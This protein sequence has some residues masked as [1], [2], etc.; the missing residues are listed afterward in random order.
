MD[1]SEYDHKAYEHL[2]NTI[3]YKPIIKTQA[4]ITQSTIDKY[5]TIITTITRSNLSKEDKQQLIKYTRPHA[6]QTRFPSIYFNP[7]TH[8][9]GRPLRPI[10]SGIRWATE[11]AAIL[12]DEILKPHIA[13]NTHLPKDSFQFIQSIEHIQYNLLA[14]DHNLIQLV[15]FDVTAL[16]TSIPQYHAIQRITDTFNQHPHTIPTH[17]ITQ[18]AT[19][20]IT[21]NYF[22]FK[23][24]IYKQA[25]GIAM[26][27][28]AG[29]SIANTYMLEWDKTF[30]KQTSF[31]TFAHNYQRYLDDGFL[32]WIG[33]TTELDTFITHIN[34]ID[35]NIQIIAKY[36]KQVTYLDIDILLTPNNII[37]TR[38]HRKDTA[39]QTY[40]N[41]NSAHPQHIKNNLPRSIFFR[42]FIICNTQSSFT[43]ETQHIKERFHNSKYPLSTINQAFNKTTTQYNI[44]TTINQYQYNIARKKAISNIGKKPENQSADTKLYLPITYQPHIN[45]KQYTSD[46]AIH[47]SL[48][49]CNNNFT[50]I[51]SFKQ[52]YN[53]LRHLTKS[54]T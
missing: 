34:T 19:F 8:K 5:K 42:S 49:A 44:P 48:P 1:R 28:P 52:P 27:N 33:P 38:T 11:N 31:T 54:N 22:T 7:K 51:T 39:A 53:L 29:A 41:Y 2:I 9:E 47:K 35:K 23:E 46:T 20:V 21:N 10:V 14:Q 4:L 13:I 18:L 37:L 43:I 6:N 17:I 50:A 3:H 12:L 26:G 32:I 45:F 16:Y 40:L 25:H 15:T 30:N 24:Q 36:G